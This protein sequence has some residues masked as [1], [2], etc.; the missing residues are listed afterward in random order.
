M[1]NSMKTDTISIAGLEVKTHI[2]VP[3]SE[4]ASEQSVWVYVEMKVDAKKAGESDNIEDTIDY[5]A[6]ANRIEELAK[7]ERKT[8][9]KFAE[10]IA[11]MILSEFTPMSVKVSIKKKILPNAEAVFV[12]VDR[13]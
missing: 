13:S 6:V 2:G 8:A 12:T 1:K 10:D 3:D 5:E 4:R 9:E 7:T 11:K